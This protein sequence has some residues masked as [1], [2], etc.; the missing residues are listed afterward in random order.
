[1]KFSVCIPTYNRAHLISKPLESLIAQSF[2]DFEVIVVD[3]GSVD[4]TESVVN[5]YSDKLNI[6]YIKKTNGGKH[7][8]LNYGISN[9]HGELFIILDS[10]DEFLP[11]TLSRLNDLWI[12][13]SEEGYCGIMGRC[14]SNGELIGKPFNDS[15]K[16]MSYVEFHFGKNGG[17]YIDCC[18][19]LRL[20][21]LSRY[22][23]PENL[24]TKFIPENYVMDKLGLKSKLLL[25]NEIIQNKNYQQTD[26]I[27][28]NNQ[29]FIQK[30]LLGYL[31][32]AC[33]K[34]QDILPYA[35]K[36]EITFKNKLVIWMNYWRFEK[37]DTAKRGVRVSHI[38]PLGIIAKLLLYIKG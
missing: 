16:A 32:N 7:T 31:F 14:T 8:A 11:D 21:L 15:I 9:S 24:G 2:K 35:N 37:M 25:T 30:N 3:D 23:W 26:G 18:E 33:S 5:A 27:T 1:M 19:C 29:L 12:R 22:R 36:G 28:L 13:H 38:T 34:V 6:N 10:D 17:K 20:D 4:D